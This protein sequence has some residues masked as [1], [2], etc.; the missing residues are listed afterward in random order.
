MKATDVR[1]S[2]RNRRNL[3]RKAILLSQRTL[4]QKTTG[5]TAGVLARLWEWQL[6]RRT[7]KRPVTVRCAFGSYMICPPWSRMA[8]SVAATGLTE[9][10]D[11]LFV[12][13]VLRP[14]DLFVDVGA[15]IGYYTLLGASRGARVEAF[16]PTAEAV[17][18]CE[19]SLA[20][21]GLHATVHRAACGA[22]GGTARFTTGM[23]I[24]N[25]IT[26]GAGIDIPMVTVDS[27]LDGV[28]AALAVLKVDAEGHDL[29]VLRGASAT[30]E[31]LQPIIL[32]EIW[33]GGEGPFQLVR[34]HGYRP[35]VYD[36]DA[37]SLREV[38]ADHRQGGNLLLIPDSRLAIARERVRVGRPPLHTPQVAWI[39]KRAR[40]ARPPL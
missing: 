33:T 25:H 23:D 7:I 27:Q 1:R 2:P 32:V 4:K 30:V 20:V 15:N 36:P 37:R 5:S 12:L 31:R 34:A 35:Y 40:S 17:A 3:I 39:S 21:N 9:R 16:E 29:S 6:W 10:N 26:D 28:Q 22:E 13:D 38:S 18:Y 11:S 14:G 8:G 19:R 24:K